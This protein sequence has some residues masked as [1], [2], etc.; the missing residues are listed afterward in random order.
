M[1]IMEREKERERE[2]EIKGKLYLYIG[3]FFHRIALEGS[4]ESVHSNHLQVE[5]LTV[6]CISFL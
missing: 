3:T 2:M 4:Q 6:F 5:K 1:L